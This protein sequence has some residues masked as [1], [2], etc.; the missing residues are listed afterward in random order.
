M[1]FQAL[2][3]LLPQ[4]TAVEERS[5]MALN[6]QDWVEWFNFNGTN[7]PF[8]FHQTLSGN[9][10]SI[11]DGFE[12]YIRGIYKANGVVFACLLTRMMHFSEARFMWRRLRQGRP[13]PLFG[14]Q[15]LAPVERPWMNG[16]TGDLLCRMIQDADLDGNFFGL[17]QGNE[18]QRLYP[19]WTDIAIGSK[20][21]RAD[22]RPGDPDQTV[23]GYIYTPGGKGSDRNPIP[24]MPEQI[25]HFAPIPDPSAFYR[26]QSIITAALREVQADQSMSRHRQRF[27]DNG[28]T[29]NLVVKLTPP[30]L[31]EFNDYVRKFRESH[32]GT[33]NAYKTLFVTGATEVQPVGADMQQLEFRATQGAGETRIAAALRVHPVIVG[34]SEGMAGSSLNAG[35][36]QAARRAFADGTM[37]PLWRQAAG[38][39]QSILTKPGGAEL[40]VDTRDISFLKEDEK[41]AAQIRQMNAAAMSSLIQ[42]GWEPDAIVDAIVSDDFTQLMGQHTGLTSVQLVPPDDGTGGTVMNGKPVSTPG[43][44]SAN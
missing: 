20:T 4:R 28:A 9:T 18:I 33:D 19:G 35:N 27:F 24:F 15:N 26:G 11:A 44:V 7:Y 14:D 6:F 17:R 25:A 3:H 40:W 31:E 23:A 34:L 21:G 22:F 30:K 12:G 39:L 10:E 32:Q 2:E 38:A 41:D 42:G 16:T 29:V 5:S 37:R 43:N 36:Y 8:S 13:G 1:R